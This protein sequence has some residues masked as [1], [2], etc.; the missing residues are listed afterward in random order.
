MTA[1]AAKLPAFT[2]AREG[3]PRLALRFAVFTALGLAVAA[4]IIIF[5]VRQADTAEVERQAIGRARLATEAALNRELR[6][7]DLA[8]PVDMKRRHGLDRLFRTRVLLEGIRSAT[9][10]GPDGQVTY[11]TDRTGTG[12]RVSDPHLLQALGG[13]VVANVAATAS[14][15]VLRTY[16]PLSL[17]GRRLNGAVALDQDYGHIEAAAVRSSWLI[18]GVLEGLLLLLSLIFIPTLA[19]VT[20]RIRRSVAE[21]EQVA[22][23]DELTGLLNRLGFR[24]A[25]ELTLADGGTAG[26][27]VLS[28]ST[29]SPRSTTCSAPSGATP[30]CPTS[31]P[32]SC[33]TSTTARPSHGWARTSSACCSRP[34]VARRSPMSQSAFANRSGGPS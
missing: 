4:A 17:G 13:A 25:V 21:L 11:A 3:T 18:V 14:G 10:Y 5:V 6:A 32:G 24:K 15:R 22:T 16:V 27:V 23:H 1:R 19:H 2:S 8:A 28:T 9:L 30:Y 31:P 34:Q 20:S 29:A 26:A 33:V 7:A 12:A